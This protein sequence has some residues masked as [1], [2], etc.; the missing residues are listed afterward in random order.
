MNNFVVAVGVL[1]PV[2]NVSIDRGMDSG[3]LAM[4]ETTHATK[5]G[6]WRMSE[7]VFC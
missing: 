6:D 1:S 3:K 4:S 5:D 7:T 2:F